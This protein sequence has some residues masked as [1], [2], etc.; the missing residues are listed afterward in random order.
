[1]CTGRQNALE[2]KGWVQR[3]TDEDNVRE[4]YFLLMR[5]LVAMNEVM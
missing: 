4:K 2:P 3:K 1:M 5:K